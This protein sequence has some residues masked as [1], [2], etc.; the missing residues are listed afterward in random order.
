MRKWKSIEEI[1]SA[2]RI[3][4]NRDPKNG[5]NYKIQ[6]Q[7]EEDGEWKDIDFLKQFNL[8]ITLDTLENAQE[9]L[10]LLM[11][12]LEEMLNQY[13]K[14]NNDKQEFLKSLI[15]KGVFPEGT[16]L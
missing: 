9:F 5:N 11:L 1:R 8:E 13:K 15:D 4:D 12:I 2:H 10:E 3:V 6:I 16:H 14:S 7:E